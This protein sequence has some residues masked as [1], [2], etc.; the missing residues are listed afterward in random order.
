MNRRQRRPQRNDWLLYWFERSGF[1]K[2]ELADTVAASARRRGYRHVCPDASRVRG[3]LGGQQPRPPVPHLLADVF[4]LRI[5]VTL[6]PDDLG[7]RSA[8]SMNRNDSPAWIATATTTNLVQLSR[9]DLMLGRRDVDNDA[10]ELL[11]GHELLADV[12]P[13][14]TVA[15]DPLPTR[16]DTPHGHLGRNDV[17][18]IEAVTQALRQLDNLHGGG[19]AREAV[20]G[21]LSWAASLLEDAFYTD[22]TGRALF[23]AVA[24]LASVAGWMCF[25]VGLQTKALHY[26]RF[27]LRAAKEANDPTLGAHILNCMARQANHLKRPHDSLELVQLAL[28][29]VRNAATPTMRAMLHALE[30][31]AHAVTGHLDDFDRA[32]GAA[33]DAFAHS[34]PAEDPPWIAFFTTSEFYATIGIAH[35]IAAHADPSRADTSV[36]MIQQAIAERPADRVRSLTFDH[37]G[38]ARSYLTHNDLDGAAAAATTALDLLPTVNST[39]LRDRLTEFYTETQ[40][41]A[42]APAVADVRERIEHAL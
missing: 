15:S 20:V 25:D 7:L 12:Q 26:L 3:W 33:H 32:V 14:V 41:H 18:Q 31:R 19:L 2:S 29:G 6:T 40:P 22:D 4:S 38:L 28:Y 11:T 42:N 34:R 1:N 30:A 23:R 24:D 35:H 5:G 39:R 27:A 9:S 13:W 21:Q 37:I 17:T 16:T 10:Q 8:P 36:H